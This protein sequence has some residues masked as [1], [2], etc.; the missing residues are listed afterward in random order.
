MGGFP[1]AA[2]TSALGMLVKDA[3]SWASG[4]FLW[5]GWGRCRNGQEFAFSHNLLNPG[6]L[7]EVLL[8]YLSP[9]LVFISDVSV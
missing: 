2:R 8:L 5:V 6:G 4:L 3:G 9:A 7:Q 1:A